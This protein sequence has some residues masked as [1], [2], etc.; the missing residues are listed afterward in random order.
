[1]HEGTNGALGTNRVV[2]FPARFEKAV[3]IRLYVQAITLNT[4]KQ[5]LTRFDLAEPQQNL[6]SKGK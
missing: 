5:Q 6:D 3:A 2:S 4:D 1:M